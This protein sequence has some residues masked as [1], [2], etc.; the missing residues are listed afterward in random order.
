MPLRL[1]LAD[2]AA[3]D[4]PGT[5]GTPP[6]G[7]LEVVAQVGNATLLLRA[8]EDTQPDVAIIDI[9]M[10]PTQTTRRHSSGP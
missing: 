4:P 2:D 9:R 3:L 7:R 10:P 8:V 1:V 6:A 5:R